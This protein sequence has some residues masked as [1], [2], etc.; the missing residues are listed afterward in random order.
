MNDEPQKITPQQ[1]KY[2]LAARAARRDMLS[3]MRWCWWNPPSAPFRVGRHTRAICARLTKAIEDYRHGIS[4]YL[5]IAVPFRHGKALACDTPVLTTNGW[6]RHGDLKPGDCV[7]GFDGLPSKVLASHPHITDRLYRVT[8]SDGSSLL[9][10]PNH[11]WAVY[12]KR[13]HRDEIVETAAM[14][15]NTT[16]YGRPMYLVHPHCYL[17]NPDRAGTL[18]VHPYV[19]GAWL[20]DGRSSSPDIV[21]SKRDMIVLRECAKHSAVTWRTT[22]KTTGVVTFG[23]DFGPALRSVG[24]CFTSK[25]KELRAEKHIPWQY[26]TATMFDRLELLAG[27]LD[28]DGYYNSKDGR[29]TFTTCGERL[30]DSFI[31]LVSTFGWRVSVETVKPSVSTSGIC[32]RKDTYHIR[33]VPDLNIPCR[34][35]RKRNCAI[36]KWTRM[37]GIKSVELMDEPAECNC[38]TVEGGLYCAGKR[39]VVTHNS[40]IVSRALPAFFLGR[41]ADMQ[42]SAVLTGYGDTFVADLTGMVQKIISEPAYQQL[43]PGVVV[44][45]KKKS[46]ESWRI[47]DSVGLV[48]VAGIKGA[49]TGKTGNLIVIDDYCKNREQAESK[50]ERDR[51]WNEF[52]NSIMTRQSAPASIVIVCA[53]PWHTDDLRGRILQK[54]KDDPLFPRFEE[55]NFPASKSGPDGYD[56]LFPELYSPDWYN[57]MR[58]TLGPQDAAGLLD[59]SPVTREGA[60]FK[61][62]WFLTYDPSKMKDADRR[63]WHASMR[64]YIFVDTASAKKKDSDRTVMWVV[65]VAPDHNYYVLDGVCDHLSLSERTDAIFGLVRKWNPTNVYW[66]SIGAMADYEHILEK[67]NSEGFHFRITKLH[68]SVAKS[69]RIRWLEPVFKDGNMFFPV[70]LFY[71]DVSGVEHD[72]TLELLENEFIMYPSVRHDD[73]M[74]CLANVKHPDVSILF[75][76]TKE[77]RP[78]LGGRSASYS[79]DRARSVLF[80]R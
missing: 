17:S 63:R 55:L 39:M 58:A 20:G 40:D 56:Y 41:C 44:D 38:I 16:K 7:Y 53:T 2:E 64:R 43:F 34:I 10:H 71:R 28:T 46:I 8:F 21:A 75:P 36:N 3:F 76:T 50:T 60:W 80:R 18:P 31:E 30:R 77:S 72:L 11:E 67:Q 26:L 32:G 35:A 27:L 59:C 13:K 6:K 42:P 23:Y 74:D 68:Q 1:A 49:I 19:V 9:A 62:D 25:K 69:D 14:A 37:L 4:T 57:S 15:V 12:N 47:K 29:Y 61:R 51:V 54:M 79:K 24:L 73:M 5:L 33:F 65:G 66:E 78:E 22:H 70:R 52:A 48:T 45:P